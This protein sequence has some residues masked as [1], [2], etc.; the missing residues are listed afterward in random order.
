M[1]TRS[2]LRVP[3]ATRISRWKRTTR[4][5]S[6]T[7]SP[8]PH[9]AAALL[10]VDDGSVAFGRDLAVEDVSLKVHA[11]EAVA[12]IGPNGAGKST[13]LKTIL[14][15]VPVAEGRVT[16]LGRRPQDARRH[17]AYVAQADTLDAEFP[18]S[19]LQVVM[20]GLYREIGWG[21]RA[22]QP[23]RQAA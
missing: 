10:V 2:V 18:V 9:D 1:A 16:V 21:R 14:G 8:D 3:T 22:R 23:H 12:L 6:L 4:R 13:V 15:L 7:T 17:V 11:G 20:M 5:R 19:V